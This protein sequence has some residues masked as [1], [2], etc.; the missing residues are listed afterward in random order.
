MLPFHIANAKAPTAT[1]GMFVPAEHS[2]EPMIPIIA[3]YVIRKS[4]LNFF[5]I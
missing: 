4:V 3:L 1:T 5:G 2:N